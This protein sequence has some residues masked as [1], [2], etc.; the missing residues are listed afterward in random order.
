MV[1]FAAMKALPSYVLG[2]AL[3]A[4]PAVR[5]DG[6]GELTPKAEAGDLVSQVELAKSYEKGTGVSKSVKEAAKWYAKA[7]EQGNLD[8]QL[9]L[10]AIYFRGQSVPKDSRE[11]AK[12]FLLAATQGNAG[13][14]CQMARLHMMGAG[15][16]KDDIEAYKYALLAAAQGD[17][18]A[19]KVAMILEMRMTPEEILQA[20]EHDK[21]VEELKKLD[22]VPLEQAPTL[23]PIKPEALEPA[24]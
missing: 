13:A 10:G 11:A 1:E 19:K 20:K 2:F 23:E 15:V 12:W 9:A 22:E 7:A 14:Q 17:A 5:A 3:L 24:N 4:M 18:A 8:A 6:I 16:P 21:T